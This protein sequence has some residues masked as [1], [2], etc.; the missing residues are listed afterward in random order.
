[1]SVENQRD[2]LSYALGW[3][4]L[5]SVFGHIFCCGLPLVLGVVS[6]LT[7]FGM[8]SVS[9]PFLDSIHA[10]FDGVRVPMMG[11]SAMVLAVGW[12]AQVYATRIDCHNTGCVHEPCGSKKRKTTRLLWLATIIFA[13][14]MLAFTVVHPLG[15]DHPVVEQ[16]GI[17]G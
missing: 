11:F 9:F 12:G 3:V 13:F 14:N 15:S 1:M 2:N 8:F 4:A 10:G 16:V 17:Q 6:L 7:G 5:V